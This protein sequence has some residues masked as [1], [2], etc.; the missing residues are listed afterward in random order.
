M[1]VRLGKNCPI[2]SVF[3]LVHHTVDK[4]LLSVGKA[5]QSKRFQ[6]KAG[7]MCAARLSQKTVGRLGRE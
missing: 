2:S 7:G 3:P 6:E 1:T 5:K 4:C